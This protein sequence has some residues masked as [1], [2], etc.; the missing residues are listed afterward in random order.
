MSKRGYTAPQ[1][2]KQGFIGNICTFT[3]ILA[4]DTHLQA[5]QDRYLHIILFLSLISA[6]KTLISRENPVQFDPQAWN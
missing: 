2:L 3:S 1:S 4:I 5:V 6:L